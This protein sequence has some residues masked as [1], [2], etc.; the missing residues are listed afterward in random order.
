MAENRIV[1][2]ESYI[3]KVMTAF[4]HFDIPSSSKFVFRSYTLNIVNK[5]I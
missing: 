5:D 1:V 4:L 2:L 3:S